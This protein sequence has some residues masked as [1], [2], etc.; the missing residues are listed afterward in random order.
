[1]LI[2]GAAM[3]GAGETV[4]MQTLRRILS[5]AALC[6]PLLG[7]TPSSADPYTPGI[8]PRPIS[9]HAVTRAM[10]ASEANQSAL[11]AAELAL[12]PQPAPGLHTT[13]QMRPANVASSEGEFV[14]MGTSPQFTAGGSLVSIGVHLTYTV[15]NGS[16]LHR[17]QIVNNQ[18]IEFGM[19]YTS[20]LPDF[21][22]YNWCTPG[23]PALINNVGLVGYPGGILNYWFAAGYGNLLQLDTVNHAYRLVVEEVELADGWHLLAQNYVTGKWVDMLNGAGVA[24]VKNACCGYAIFEDFL[25]PGTSCNAGELG[26]GQEFYDVNMRALFNKTWLPLNKIPTGDFGYNPRDSCANL[27][28]NN[29][30]GV[31]PE[32]IGGFVSPNASAHAGDW[33]M[34]EQ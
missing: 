20:T 2:C 9:A 25:T 27:S 6:M 24:G 33:W 16:F 28:G 15:P 32:F 11:L 10:N 21:Y 22:A 30:G 12:T 31:A 3:S 17:H 34:W 7:A 1:M 29:A 23:A 4:K 5:V 14:G 8:G 26:S 19:N 18:C 13:A